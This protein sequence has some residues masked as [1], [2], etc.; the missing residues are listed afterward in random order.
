MWPIAA[1]VVGSAALTYLGMSEASSASAKAAKTAAKGA[2]SAAEIQAQS[3]REQLEYLK[4]INAL[5][6]ELRNEA[7]GQLAGLSGIGDVET[8]RA[9]IDRAKASPYYQEMMSGQEAGE[10]AVM[11]RASMTGGIRGGDV[12]AGLYDYASQLQNRALSD[13]YTQEVQNLRGL[14]GLPT[15]Q[16][17]IAQ[18]IGNIGAT[19]AGGVYNA[20]Q[21]RSQGQM[22]QGQI[23]QQGLQGMGNILMG[24]AGMA[25]KYPRTVSPSVNQSQYIN[26]APADLSYYRG[27]V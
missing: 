8:Q 6:T 15:G 4:E 25:M 1:A 17:S 12:Q 13:A 24:G 16:E 10:E 21:A 2:T 22:A 5:P 18:T 14:A 20:A 23:F 9:I 11:R 19:E 27:L 3:Q 26:Q 7:L